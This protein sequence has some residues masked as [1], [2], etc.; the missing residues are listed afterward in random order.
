MQILPLLNPSSSS[1]AIVGEYAASADAGFSQMFDTYLGSLP[2]EITPV[3]QGSD[4]Y[5]NAQI[6]HDSN[7]HTIGSES[8]AFAQRSPYASAVEQY[9]H[10]SVD[11]S[12]EEMRYT[13]AEVRKLAK[14]LQDDGVDADAL[15]ELLALAD[16]PMGVTAPDMLLAMASAVR[17]PARLT[18]DD[19]HKIASFVQ[20]IDPDGT[21]GEG[22]L[23][24]IR[25]GKTTQVWERILGAMQALDP[26]SALRLDRDELIALGKGLG[27]SNQT[28]NT[29]FKAF[30]GAGSMDLAP[31]DFQ[32]FATAMQH[33]L[34]D[35]TARLEALAQSFQKGLGPL[36]QEARMRTNAEASAA[37]R[38][39]RSTEQSKVLIQDTVTRNGLNRQDGEQPDETSRDGVAANKDLHTVGPAAAR[40]R[41]DTAHEHG[42]QTGHE[43]DGRAPAQGDS[44]KSAAKSAKQ[45]A[46]EELIDR[47][48]YRADTTGKATAAA[49]LHAPVPGMQPVAASAAQHM[50]QAQ[51]NL[52]RYAPQVLQQVEQ[53]LLS[54]LRDGGQKLELQL[55][56]EHLGT[57]SV[58]LTVKNGEVSALLRP[59][60]SETAQLLTQQAEQLRAVLE[61]QGLKVDK[62]EVQTQMQD[63]RNM[64]WQGMD[65]HNA[66]RDQQ[67]RSE[68]QNHM[69]RM[70]RL[71]RVNSSD[72]LDRNMHNGM[73]GVRNTANSAGGGLHIIT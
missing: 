57:L 19:M 66:A 16:N 22:L 53:G 27:L 61:Q 9:G 39:A 70:G 55:S 5:L 73:H 26:N 24:D 23:S 41:G 69:L 50:A 28:L 15:R 20:R 64:N 34:A 14:K 4:S 30:G 60:R 35:R 71:R 36:A 3:L 63:G 38:S 7:P 48:R 58:V 10:I 31:G 37:A 62:V 44:A 29:M 65:Q 11:Q 56:P 43:R 40:Q 32:Q 8:D 42:A 67:A 51:V 6:M 68:E 47:I 17:K 12:G 49:E 52:P 45:E 1:A 33:E 18:D 13:T 21:L 59:E 72:T 46:W 54:T 25:A 2:A